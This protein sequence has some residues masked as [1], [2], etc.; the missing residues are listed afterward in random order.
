MKFEEFFFGLIG[1][2][3]TLA[4][5]AILV[6]ILP[7]KTEFK[8]TNCQI[9]PYKYQASNFPL[10]ISSNTITMNNTEQDKDKVETAYNVRCY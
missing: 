3:A 2:V 1:M 7:S 5:F 9:T 8:L 4:I 6:H 10:Y